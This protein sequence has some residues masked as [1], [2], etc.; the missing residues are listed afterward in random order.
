MIHLAHNLTL[1]AWKQCAHTDGARGVLSFTNT[2]FIVVLFRRI[3]APN[4]PCFCSDAMRSTVNTAPSKTICVAVRRAEG[5]H[6]D[7]TQL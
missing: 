2:K 1:S 7:N 5:L 4:A 6:L 3:A